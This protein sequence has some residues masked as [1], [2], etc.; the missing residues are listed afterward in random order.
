MQQADSLIA[1]LELL[2]KWNRVYNLT[3]VRDPS[4]M[5][6]RHLLDSLSL[7]AP[8]RRHTADRSF[9]LLDVGSGAG[10][11]GVVVAAALPRADVTCL[12][13]VAKKASFVRQVGVELRLS[14][15]QA[16]H[17]RVERFNS[18]AFDV[19]TARAFAS[20]RELV[21]LSRRHVGSHGV[22]VAMK[23]QVPQAEIDG[24]GPE[25]EVFHV[26]LLSLPS[27]HEERCA[28]WMRLR[29]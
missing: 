6:N 20:L 8:L 23:G 15:L 11:P 16:E 10:L 18:P 28:V 21:L 13:A 3:A 2:R 17:A 26:E 1:Y 24:L 29:Q 19:V 22:W 4:E 14:N 27:L 9:R 7:V 5:F 25:I 12:D